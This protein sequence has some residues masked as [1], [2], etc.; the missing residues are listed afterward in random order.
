MGKTVRHT[1][2]A[3]RTAYVN[4]DFMFEI[5]QKILKEASCARYLALVHSKKS[6][7]NFKHESFHS[8]FPW[9]EK[10]TLLCNGMWHILNTPVGLKCISMRFHPKFPVWIKPHYSIVRKSNFFCPWFGNSRVPSR[11]QYPDVDF[12]TRCRSI[13]YLC[14]WVHA[15][16]INNP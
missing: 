11:L 5:S 13:G 9:F 16:D 14:L 10:H 2:R 3:L 8:I 15:T 1:A 6:R 12:H 4:N 7:L